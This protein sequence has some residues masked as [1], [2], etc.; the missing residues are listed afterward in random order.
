MLIVHIH[1]QEAF[2]RIG[3]EGEETRGSGG[4][5]KGCSEAHRTV[6]T[7]KVTEEGEEGTQ[8]M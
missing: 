1:I 7:D 8:K 3:T 2:A 6:E 5:A 4:I